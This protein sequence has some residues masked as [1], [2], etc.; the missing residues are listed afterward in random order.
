MQRHTP[1]ATTAA[2][3][4]LSA[5]RKRQAQ[6]T[7]RHPSLFAP[8]IRICAIDEAIALAYEVVAFTIYIFVH[9]CMYV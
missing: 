7:Q 1:K 2:E 5:D 6:S 4:Q 3:L 9:I 8:A